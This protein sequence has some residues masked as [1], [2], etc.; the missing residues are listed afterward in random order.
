MEREEKLQKKRFSTLDAW[1]RFVL[2]EVKN[3]GFDDWSHF[4]WNFKCVKIEV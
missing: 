3:L 4:E 2:L 1:G